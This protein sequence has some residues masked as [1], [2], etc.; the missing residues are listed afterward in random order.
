MN[1]A[2]ARGMVRL[3]WLISIRECEAAEPQDGFIV[4]MVQMG[5]LSGL[6]INAGLAT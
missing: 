6:K 2:S 1:E 5:C 3:S 4:E